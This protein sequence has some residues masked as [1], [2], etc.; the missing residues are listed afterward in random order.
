MAGHYT[1]NA[2]KMILLASVFSSLMCSV[3]LIVSVFIDSCGSCPPLVNQFAFFFLIF[4][5]LLGGVGIG[6]KSEV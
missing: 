5:G 3:L 6:I 2:T 4:S 1:L